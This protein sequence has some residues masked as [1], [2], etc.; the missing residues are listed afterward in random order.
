MK[1][2]HAKTTEVLKWFEEITKIPRCSKKEEKIVAWL[3][4][5]AKTNNFET[6]I[7]DINNIVIKVPA[8]PGFENSPIII[9]Q[10]HMD[11]VCEKTPDS[12]H[13]FSKDP[14]KLVYDG[15]WL[16]ADRTTLGADNGIAI[17][18]AMAFAEDK[19][20]AHPQLELLFTVDEETGLTGANEIQPGFI[21]GKILLNID[22]EDEGVFT[23]GCAGG[24]NTYSSLSVSFEDIPAGYTPLKLTA[25]GMKG[26][27]SGLDI[28]LGKAN[29]I[30]VLGRVIYSLREEI[31]VRVASIKGGSAH[32][33]IPRDAEAT[34]FLPEDKIDSAKSS[35]SKL[36]ATCNSEFKITDPDLALQFI[37]SDCNCTKAMSSLDTQK[38]VQYIYA[39]PHGVAAMSPDIEGLVETSNN[40]ANISVEDEEIRVLTSQ[41]SSVVSRLN[42]H[43]N[44]IEAV[45][46]LAGGKAKSSDG[47]PPWQPNMESPLLAT[48]KKLYKKMFDKEPVVEIIHAGLECGII[49]DKFDG[50]DMISIG[51]DLR[52]PHC[53]DE[54]VHIGAIGKVWDFIAELFKELK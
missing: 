44:R 24:I 39:M 35:L 1:V 9:I 18:M 26:G 43:T 32:N 13:D 16:T 4:D 33:A 5:W 38:L 22:S 31:D 34:V 49:G 40:F 53:P 51:P 3:K 25:G 21:D 8:S 42:A 30:K 7:D 12:D 50:M 19:D 41:R 52:Y 28:A 46:R 48:S 29:A 47:Y 23:V 54:K 17:A 20:V 45:T 27:H 11:M 37:P 10:G 14:L 6:K 36:S 2:A 15:E